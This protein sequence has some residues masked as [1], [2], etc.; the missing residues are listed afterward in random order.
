MRTWS[1][2]IMIF[3]VG[4]VHAQLADSI[5]LYFEDAIGNKDS[6]LY[7]GV[8]E[9][10]KIPE[11][12]NTP[13]FNKL[14]EEFDVA[15]PYFHFGFPPPP[16]EQMFTEHVISVWRKGD[17]YTRNNFLFIRIKHPPL[18]MYF[19]DAS[20]FDDPRSEGSYITSDDRL[21]L[22]RPKHYGD[23]DRFYCLKGVDTLYWY[24]GTEFMHLDVFP[25]YFQSNLSNGT[26]DTVWGLNHSDLYSSAHD[27]GQPCP[28]MV[29]SDDLNLSHY[30]NIFQ[31]GNSINIENRGP[32]E[33]TS[34]SIF[35]LEGKLVSY[36]HGLNIAPN[37]NHNLNWNQSSSGVFIIRLE[38]ISGDVFTMRLVFV[39]R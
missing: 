35:T 14:N 29:D 32:V 22:I 6:V 23:L 26:V 30:I 18:K 33:I 9:G 24:L 36:H 17:F 31:S 39:D 25:L 20:F 34:L 15:I 37:E 38:L 5:W 13:M 1:A 4:Q 3:F 28:M 27:I 7:G 16:D 12:Y 10:S 2:I 11:K 19:D 8:E 21:A